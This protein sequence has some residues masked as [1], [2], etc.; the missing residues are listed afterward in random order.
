T[1]TTVEKEGFPFLQEQLR[2]WRSHPLWF[3]VLQINA[4][5]LPLS[6]PSNKLGSS[7]KKKKQSELLEIGVKD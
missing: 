1:F 3:Q 7:L 2:T 6:F 4:N 5:R